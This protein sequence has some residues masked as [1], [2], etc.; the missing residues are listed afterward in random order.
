MHVLATRVIF[1]CDRA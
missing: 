1:I